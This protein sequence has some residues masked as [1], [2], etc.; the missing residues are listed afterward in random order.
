MPQDVSSL[1]LYCVVFPCG[2]GCKISW[3]SGSLVFEHGGPDLAA[4]YRLG[5]LLG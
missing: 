3:F 4:D 1:Q 2:I 5:M